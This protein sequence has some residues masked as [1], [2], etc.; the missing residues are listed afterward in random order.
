MMTPCGKEACLA[1]VP[2]HREKTVSDRELS[3]ASEESLQLFLD[4]AP[5]AIVVV[6]DSGTMVAVNQLTAEL[7]GFESGELLGR[8]VEMLVPERYHG[9]HAEQRAAY[10]AEPRT[11]PMGAGQELLGLRKDGSEFPVQIS[12]SPLRT[13]AGTRVISIIR[14]VTALKRAEEK[15]RGLL[16]SAP[17]AIVVVDQQGRMA[18]VNSEAERMF[19]Y[20]RAELLGREIEML[21]PERY[22]RTHVG[23]RERYSAAPRTRP[24]AAGRE[25]AALRRDG[26][27]FPVEIS[28]SPLDTD[29]GL[30]VTSIIRDMTDRVRAEEERRNLIAGQIRAEEI[31][32]A[33]DQFLMTLSHELRTP[34][35]AILGW[36]KLVSGDETDP[37]VLQEALR[38]IEKSAEAQARI[39]DDVLEVSRMITGKTQL[40]IQLTDPVLVAHT[41][42]QTLRPSAAAKRIR[43]GAVIDPD[44]GPLPADPARLQQII[45]N[46]VSNAI[47]F[48]D[49]GSTVTL[50]IEMSGSTLEIAVCDQGEGI[51]PESLPYVFEPFYQSDATTTRAHGGLGLGL[52]VVRQ[53]VELHGGR[54]SVESEGRGKGATFRAQLP[55][56]A[57]ADLEKSE[58]AVGAPTPPYYPDLGG[59]R[60]LCVDD[61]EESRRL[62]AAVLR[63]A[64]ATVRSEPGASGAL[65]ALASWNPEVVLTDIAMPGVDGLTLA[66]AIRDRDAEVPV[67]ALSAVIRVEPE[68]ESLFDAF[69]RKPADPLAIAWA[70]YET[71]ASRR[72]Q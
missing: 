51:P 3:Y 12:L 55:V 64:N 70:V 62:V 9:R 7:F 66:R 1:P 69:L 21:V 11:R 63:R 56:R 61:D 40:Q 39:I 25:L 48:S 20:P 27:E 54:I 17:D 8:K 13:D 44:V 26:S 42:L 52:S 19:G 22:R 24:M 5:D 15:F 38:T 34:L 43:L 67:I 65:E 46:L 32:R 36:A 29:Q 14:D 53:L 6:D 72:S 49:K 68:D 31:S 28:L 30:L 2:A 18:I 57:T 23:D 10:T 50:E 16:E 45:W 33:K 47:K 60:V 58:S 41:V 37:A 4:A 71:L 59:V 35:T